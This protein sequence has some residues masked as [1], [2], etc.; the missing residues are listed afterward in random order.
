VKLLVANP[1]RVSASTFRAL[2]LRHLEN[3]VA[4]E[5]K[6]EGHSALAKAGVV[7]IC[8]GRT[9]SNM[10]PTFTEIPPAVNSLPV[11]L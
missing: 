3:S 1:P 10:A 7:V 8:L 5:L 11:T 6:G 4:R 2:R 9:Q